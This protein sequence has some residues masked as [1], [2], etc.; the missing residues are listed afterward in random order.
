MRFLI[1]ALL[2]P[3]PAL[4]LSPEQM[5]VEAR[6]GAW[7]V[8]CDSVD[9]MNGRIFFDCW[10]KGA[11]GLY[12]R[13]TTTQATLVA[14]PGTKLTGLPISPCP[15]GSCTPPLDL[16]SLLTILGD[17]QADGT[18]LDPTGF[19]EAFTAINRLLKR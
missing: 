18:P 2:L 9:D 12:A 17:V 14:R 15:K 3:L 16:A 8:L 6:F 13:A 19:A 4:A 11:P 7:T 10:A 1:L 5:R